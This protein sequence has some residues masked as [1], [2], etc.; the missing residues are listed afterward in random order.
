MKR[1]EIK[2]IVKTF[3]GVRALDNVSLDLHA[4][5]VLGL[6]GENGAGKSTLAKILMGIYSPDSG[7]LRVNGEPVAFGNPRDAKTCGITMIHQELS[8]ME[9]MSVMENIL[10]V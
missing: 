2:N 6:L 8:L 4:G 9:N 1:L 3:P 5:E 10:L 7:E